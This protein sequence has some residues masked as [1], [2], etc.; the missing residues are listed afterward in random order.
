[1]RA[2]GQKSSSMRRS[3]VKSGAKLG[4]E[5][6]LQKPSPSIRYVSTRCGNRVKE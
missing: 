1:M 4:G 2:I 5:G 3:A 6:K